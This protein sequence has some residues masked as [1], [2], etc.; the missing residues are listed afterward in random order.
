[1]SKSKP[2]GR[3][4]VFEG[5]DGS[6]TTTQ[7]SWSADWL[8]GAGYGVHATREPT[9]GPI[10]TMIRQ[11]LAKRLVSRGGAAG[12][13]PV[14]PATVA[15]LFAADRLDHLQNEIRP[16]LAAGD[17]VLC[18]RYTLSSLAYQSVDVDLRFV[19]AIN[20]RALAPD[21]TIFLRVRPE[22]AMDRI[23]ATRNN[24]DVFET[25][26]FQRK[27]A[28]RY[29]QLISNYKGGRVVELDGEQDRSRVTGQVRSAIEDLL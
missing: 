4:I 6:G 28:Q 1:M 26:P 7:A 18:D 10:G 5:I 15:L 20:E 24:R 2:S 27:V 11:I 16:R 23:A 13:E 14:D 21:L 22:T 8:R 3:F 29:D 25:L 9:G 12:E 17:V 19:R